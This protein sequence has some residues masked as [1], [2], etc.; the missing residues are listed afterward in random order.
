MQGTPTTMEVGDLDLGTH[1]AIEKTIELDTDISEW[2]E[3]L[4]FD[5]I[6]TKTTCTCE[7]KGLSHMECFENSVCIFIA[8]NVPYDCSPN[9]YRRQSLE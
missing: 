6:V 8:S 1:I 7:I 3:N 9:P 2:L 4:D 5:F